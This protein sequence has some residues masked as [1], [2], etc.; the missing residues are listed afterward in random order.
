MTV[1][2]IGCGP[3]YMAE[4]L[5]KRGINV[6]SIDRCITQMTRQFSSEVIET[7]IETCNFPSLNVAPDRI[8]L[9]DIIEHLNN[10]EGL[11]LQIRKTFA[12]QEVPQLIITS[13]N[14][15]FFIVR[16][17]LLLGQFNYGKKGIL[18]KDHHRLFTF[19]SMKRLLHIAGYTIKEV[20]GIPAPFPLAIGNN[21]IS[22]FLLFVNCLL[23]RI[24]PGLFAYQMGFVAVPKPMIEHLLGRAANTGE[25][26]LKET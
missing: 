3:G 5:H 8:F 6:I 4:E 14:I 26:I 24:W 2:D 20:K 12:N 11:L 15:G 10:P 19:G 13:G 16:F 7:E 9:L 17:G 25:K 22:R 1:L 23:I 18:D 21:I